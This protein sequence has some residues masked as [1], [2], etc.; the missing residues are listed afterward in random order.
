MTTLNQ[1]LSRED[2]VHETS[3]I[4]LLLSSLSR[5]S[6]QSIYKIYLHIIA[7]L[8][9]QLRQPVLSYPSAAI[10]SCLDEDFPEGLIKAIVEHKHVRH[11]RREVIT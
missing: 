9:P 8:P 7:P 4:A 10:A 1:L 11:S 3:Q 2:H 6:H 5:K